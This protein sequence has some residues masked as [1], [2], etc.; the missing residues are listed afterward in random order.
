MNYGIQNDAEFRKLD[1]LVEEH[2][3]PT[4]GSRIATMAGVVDATEQ[5]EKFAELLGTE[6]TGGAVSAMYAKIMHDRDKKYKMCEVCGKV[7][8]S[9]A[10]RAEAVKR[11]CPECAVV[12]APTAIRAKLFKKHREWS[13]EE[14]VAVINAVGR[15]TDTAAWGDWGQMADTLGICNRNT[16]SIENKFRQVWRTKQEEAERVAQGLPPLPERCARTDDVS[17]ELILLRLYLS[18]RRKRCD[19][20]MMTI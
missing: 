15:T 11:W 13:N 17:Q 19:D 12:A 8:A 16:G 1:S 14:M 5:W 4:K 18:D 9:H 20:D 2:G 6:R 3:H 7:K 10:L